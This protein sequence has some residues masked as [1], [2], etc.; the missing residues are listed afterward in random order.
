MARTIGHR[1]GI[2][3]AELVAEAEAI[4][5]ECQRLGLTG[6]DAM[7]AHV[8]AQAGMAS[9]VLRDEMDALGELVP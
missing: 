1:V 2:D 4:A 3:P 9:E 7:V 6:I 5:R 8:A